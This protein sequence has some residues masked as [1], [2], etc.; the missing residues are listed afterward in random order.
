M[1]RFL[2]LFLG[3][4]PIFSVMGLDN[5]DDDDVPARDTDIVVVKGVSRKLLQQSAT[6]AEGKQKMEEEKLKFEID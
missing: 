6:D 1:A 2:W 4:G 5:D 3:C